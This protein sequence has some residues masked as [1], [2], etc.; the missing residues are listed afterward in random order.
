[1]SKTNLVLPSRAGDQFHYLWAARRCLHL[2]SANNDLV[3]I[4]I[5]GVSTQENTNEALASAGDEVIDIAEYFGSE[6][7][8]E[9]RLVRYM[10]L[11]H[12]TLRV[13][14]PWTSSGLETTIKGFARRYEELL[15]IFSTDVLAEKIEFWFVTNRPISK[16][17]AEVVADAAS[18]AVPRH[19]KKLENLER[20]TEL[21]GQTLGAF[22]RLLRFVDREDDYW[23]QRNILSQSVRDYLPEADVYGPLKLKELVTRRALPERGHNPT[24]TKMDVLRALDTDESL[25]FPAPCLIDSIDTTVPRAQE[26][27]FLRKIVE[28][29]TSVIVHASAGVGKTVFA[30]R[31][32]RSLPDGSTCVLYDCFG[33]GQYRNASSYRHRHKDALVQIANELASQGLCHP[34]IP[35]VHADAT[36]YLKAFA[37]RIGQAA[38]SL[39]RACHRGLICIVVDAADNAQMA[40]EEVGET[41]SFVRDLIRQKPPEG[42]RLVFL[43]RSHRQ[44]YLDPPV[45]AI[46]LRLRPFSR[47]ETA[48]HLRQR[49]KYASKHDINEFHRLSSE[50]PRVQALALSQHTV[51]SSVLRSL[52]PNPTTIE[53]TIEGLLEGAIERLKDRAETIEKNQIDKICEG[54]A[55]LRP[56]IPVSILSKMSGVDQEAIKSFAI[57]L[58]RP[59]LVTGDTI[60]FFDEPAESW[61]REKFKPSAAIMVELIANL[62]P[63]A[64]TSAYVA[65]ALPQLMLEAGKF[66]DLVELALTSDALPETSPLE[67]HDVELQ[68]LQFALKAGLRSKRYLASVK[69]ALKAGGETAGDERKRKILQ[70]NTDLAAVF[71]DTDLIQEIVSRRT[72]GSGWLGSQHVYEAAFLSGR[73]ELVGDARSRLRMALEWLDNWSRLTPEERKRERIS[74]QD[75]SELTLAHINIHGPA[76][77]A[78]SLSLWRPREISFRVGLTV[79]RRLLDHG[80]FDDVEAMARAAGSNICLVLAITF[81]LRKIQRI[82]P[83]DLIKRALRLIAST[84]VK[85]ESG[86]SWGNDESPLE[87]ITALVEVGLQEA[88][89]TAND[90]TAIL[91]RY[92]PSEPPSVLSHRFSK[93]RLPIL[94]A[95]CLRAALQNHELTLNDLAH[96]E[97][98]IEIE[99]QNKHSISRDAR[100]FQ[101]D[102]GRLLPWHQLWAATIIGRVTRDSLDEELSRTRAASKKAGHTYD[103]DEFHAS[104]EIAWIWLCVLH[105]LDSANTAMLSDF[106]NWKDE[107]RRALFTPTLTALARLCGQREAT[108]AVALEFALEA[109]N[110]TK[111]ERSGAESTSEGYV[112][113]ARSVLTISQSDAEAYF[114][115]AVEVA[116]KIGDEN[117]PRWEA[118][119]DLA[120]RAARTDR[121]SPETAYRF[122]RCAELTYEYV[123]R[124]KYF[125]WRATT[126][127]LC[128]LCPSSAFAIL[129][130]WRDRNFGGPEQLLPVAVSR[131]VE[132]GRLDARDAL[133]LI[134]FRADWLY[135]KLMD[136][137]LSACELCQE[138]ERIAAYLFRYA[139]FSSG[140][141]SRL[142]KVAAQH[143]I[144][145]EGLDQLIAFAETKEPDTIRSEPER[146]RKPNDSSP[147][148]AWACD[149]IF[150]D[151]ELKS[152]NDLYRAYVM[153]KSKKP[154]RNHDEFFKEAVRRTKV[155]SEAPFIKAFGGISEFGLY[156]LR[157]LLDQIPDAWTK[158]P[159]IRR[160]LREVLKAI[161][162]RCCMEISKN[163]Y[164]QI[165]PFE[166]AIALAELSET[167]IAGIV[168]DAVG[169]SPDFADYDRLF[170]LSS[171]LAIKLSEDEA[172]EALLFGLD[173][174]APVLEDDVGDGQWS[175]ELLPPKDVN[176]SLAGYIWAS[177]AAPEATLRWGGAHAVLGLVALGRNSILGHL[178]KLAIERKGGP[179]ADA[180]LPFYDLHALQWFLIGIARAATEFPSALK[181]FSD[182]IV[183]W[184]LK[185]QPH[186]IIRQFAASAALALVKD[187]TLT[188]KEDLKER[189]ERVN[190]SSFPVEETK[191][192]DRSF[193]SSTNHTTSDDK[194]SF[195]F[196]WDI[197]HYWYEP[198]GR[199]FALSQEEIEAEAVRVIRTDLGF[200]SRGRWNEDE[201]ARRKLYEEKHTRHSHGSYPRADTLQFYQ[202]Y[203]ALMIVA[204]RR[205]ANTP[206]R[207]NSEYEESGRFANWLERHQC[208]RNDGRWLWDRRDPPPLEQPNWQ[209]QKRSDD[210][211]RKATTDEFDEALRADNMLNLWG[212]WTF[213]D[214]KYEES[215]SIFS[216]LVVPDRS[217]ALLRALSTAKSFH[218]YAIPSA[219]SDMEIEESG[220]LLKGW[221]TDYSRDC[222]LDGQDRWSG[223]ISFPPPMPARYIVESMNISTDTDIRLWRDSRQSVVMISQVWGHYNEAIRNES[224]NPER[225]SRIQAHLDFVTSMLTKLNRDLIVEVKID[226]RHRYKPYESNYEDDEKSIETGVRLYLFGADGRIRT[227]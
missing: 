189:L 112:D 91:S 21:T 47:D 101:E 221:I 226:R 170:S 49:F 141:F 147:G 6:D 33:N 7:I 2:L 84:R 217:L 196:G 105:K 206:V 227:L 15:K 39:Q 210:V 198:L 1:M 36:A 128:G 72:F 219:N 214:S 126:E 143:H 79:T 11:K 193:A 146:A 41:R 174:Y 156:E 215:V 80:R 115:E 122:A 109:F 155:G 78:H 169:Q 117:L 97:L 82:L 132:R 103:L 199:V 172:N 77:G 130:R 137:V 195:S 73:K 69:L 46:R 173:L 34:L 32:A 153:L 192:Y 188:G 145:I 157:S 20:F 168:L 144:T 205:L 27:D 55:A 74:D 165:F 85:L 190:V 151:N 64:A 119:L 135:Y 134:G 67:K 197:G 204:G 50:N 60:Q 90:A 89:C 25:L 116:S 202:S 110:L 26:A 76:D 14:E 182:Q 68:R 159:A 150:S 161:C 56:L 200:A 213:V 58:G 186:V 66:S 191:D 29:T 12:S 63:L 201:R 31:I 178:V 163:R 181:P 23:D 166:K 43:C 87:A 203:H 225:G 142:G 9:A 86:R 62:K 54:L 108:K 183:D 177:M 104:N 70:A 212:Y 88:L 16:D 92:L 95:Y 222:N 171:L 10:Q 125:N 99:K 208:I 133:P 218:N 224:H 42:V 51:L 120:D 123:A 138:K 22:L 4:S 8:Q 180:K 57:D 175:N 83:A 118:I 220:F 223:G 164:Y 158:R 129:S 149:D 140:E 3:A 61:F 53:D 17:V 154:P 176:A 152:A 185:D 100:E 127:A 187:G 107:Q 98:R 48:A 65:S 160:A 93:A 216:A 18:K 19:P 5:E 102:I 59:L 52:G 179:F 194:D 38:T 167:E 148:V 94:R 30:N 121:A 45:D 28:A 114:N 162:R 106:S 113:A 35:T 136:D 71:L 96:V 75:I 207:N 184:A 44:D 209:N 40:A 37:H 13:T 111:E 124:D 139:Q 81:E 24:I 211:L 131:L